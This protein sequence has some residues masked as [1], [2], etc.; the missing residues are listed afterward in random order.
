[1]IQILNFLY[2]LLLYLLQDLAVLQ[3][4]RSQFC[5]FI[6]LSILIDLILKR[7][8]LALQE[9]VSEEQIGFLL[10]EFED[11]LLEIA[12]FISLAH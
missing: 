8:M 4:E 9:L 1:M 10:L 6:A 11:G 7:L 2:L 12:L 5:I 3:L